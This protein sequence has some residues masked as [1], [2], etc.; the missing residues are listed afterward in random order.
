MCPLYK[1]CW[2]THHVFYMIVHVHYTF[3]WGKWHIELANFVKNSHL[4]VISLQKSKF[5]VQYNH[6]LD[7]FIFSVHNLDTIKHFFHLLKNC[8]LRKL[9]L[10]YWYVYMK[11]FYNLIGRVQPWFYCI[12]VLHAANYRLVK[13]L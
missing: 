13:I 4:C 12:N 7:I 8:D 2:S 1:F 5:K 6:N 10:I 9:I 3:T 11:I